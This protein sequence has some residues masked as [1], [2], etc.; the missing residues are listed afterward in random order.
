MIQRRTFCR[1]LYENYLAGDS[2]WSMGLHERLQQINI[3][4]RKRREK[5]W[6][7]LV[8]SIQPKCQWEIYD[9]REVLLLRNIKNKKSRANIKI[10]SKYSQEIPF[11]YLN[12]FHWVESHQNKASSH[13]PKSTTAFLEKKEDWCKYWIYIFIKIPAKS[14]DVSPMD[15][16]GF[17]LL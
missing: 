14:P 6:T 12:D 4:R 2:W 15:C 7:N 9:S 1:T 5:K 16:C 11:L 10:N 17:G 3:Y 8:L 13:T